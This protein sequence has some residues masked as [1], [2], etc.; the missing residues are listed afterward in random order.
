MDWK[1]FLL[2]LMAFLSGGGLIGLLNWHN[3]RKKVDAE[4]K[5]TT[6]KSSVMVKGAEIKRL[7]E[8]LDILFEQYQQMIEQGDLAEQRQ[9]TR[10]KA[11]EGRIKALEEK[12][13]ES[14]RGKSE[15][16]LQLSQAYERITALE[17]QVKE[18]TQQNKRRESEH[19]ARE[20]ELK[21][22][23]KRLREEL[24][25]ARAGM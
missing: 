10:T 5:A 9:N 22:E 19:C 17:T 7:S 2:A 23:I 21:N 15:M 16:Q 18:L 3:A 8:A 25:S 1:E 11:L 4:V 20:K 13:S 12:L 14:Q 6:D 24:E